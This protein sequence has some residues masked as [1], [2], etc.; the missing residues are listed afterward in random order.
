MKFLS[1]R[2]EQSKAKT[3]AIRV[4]VKFNALR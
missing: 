2:L 3:N 1:D 4:A